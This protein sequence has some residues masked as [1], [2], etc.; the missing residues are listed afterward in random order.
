MPLKSLNSMVS[1]SPTRSSSDTR[2]FDVR[3][4]WVS[5]DRLFLKPCW[6]LLMMLLFSTWAVTSVLTTCSMS[7]QQIQVREIGL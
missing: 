7:L 6:V 2:S 1:V 5:H 3:I 4:S